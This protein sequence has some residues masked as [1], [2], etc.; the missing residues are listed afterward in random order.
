MHDP[1]VLHEDDSLL[2]LNKPAGWVTTSAGTTGRSPVVQEWLSKTYTYPLSQD[3]ERRSGLVHR[4][5]K[6]TSGI[7][8]VGKT[9]EA[10]EFLQSQ[11]ADRTI[12]KTYTALA[13]G[14]FKVKKG[15]VKAEVGR[16]PWNRERFGIVPGGRHSETSFE[17]VKEYLHGKD[18]VSLVSLA[19]KT[20]RTHQIRIH[21]KFLGHPIVSDIFYAGRKTSRRDLEWCSRMFLHSSGITFTHPLTK[22]IM[23]QTADLPGELQQVLDQLVEKQ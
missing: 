18:V 5:D 23:A 1:V 12:Q 8:V 17:I 21:L 9:Q 22:K 14:L 13:H 19:P 11:F 7:L 16:L 2:L 4:L 6:E 15:V 10:Y 20:G 3:F